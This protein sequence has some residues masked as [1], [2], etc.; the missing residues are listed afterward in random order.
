MGTVLEE[1]RAA[2]PVVQLVVGSLRLRLGAPS[3]AEHQMLIR[4]IK[5]SCNTNSNDT[6]ASGALL[7]RTSNDAILHRACAWRPLPVL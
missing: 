6:C 2:L 5:G 3:A 4:I 7:G 1:L